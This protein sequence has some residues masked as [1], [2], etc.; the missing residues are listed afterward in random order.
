MNDNTV[1]N[2]I[3]LQLTSNDDKNNSYFL[4]G[5]VMNFSDEIRL[6]LF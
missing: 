6:A 4:A 2:I 3:Y 1:S 5:K